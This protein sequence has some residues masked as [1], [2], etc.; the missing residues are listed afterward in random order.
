MAG[1]RR[2]ADLTAV[3]GEVPAGAEESATI[4]LRVL[5]GQTE[6]NGTLLLG[7]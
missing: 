7:P 3:L 6:I 2:D 5:P 4:E 1:L